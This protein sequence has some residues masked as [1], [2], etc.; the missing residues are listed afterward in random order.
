MSRNAT[1]GL[2]QRGRTWHIDKR[3]KGYGRLCE[4]CGTDSLEEAEKYLAMRLEQIRRAHV[5]GERPAV[6][7]DQAA[8]K[9][10][11]EN[12]HKKSIERDVISLS[13]VMP[14]IGEMSL[15]LVHDGSLQ[16]YK[17]DRLASGKAAGTINRELGAVRR[18]LNLAA[19]AW[20]HD[21][22]MAYLSNTPLIQMLPD[23]QCRKPYPINT[24]EQTRLF[25]QMSEHLQ[26]A[27]LFAL[28]T[29]LREAELCNLQWD[30]EVPVPELETSV[31]ILPERVTKTGQERVVMLNKVARSVI[32]ARRGKHRTHVFSY[33]GKPV[34]R[35]NNSGFRGARRRAGL[36]QV[37]VHDLRHTFGHRLRAAGVSLEDRKDLLGHKS[38]EITTHYSA[39][40]LRRLLEGA[41][42][43]CKKRPATILRVAS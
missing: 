3:I 33:K 36:P 40:D 39:P 35:L 18:I 13:H 16:Q 28:N 31:F 30:W 37:R 15:E 20:R 23:Q 25:A 17:Q 1:R 43:I 42:S 26:Q 2:Q 19:R 24:D 32:R 4:S 12:Q 6:T 14:Y 7:F 9:Y 34:T 8:A 29:G 27:C 10:V 11:A 41:E 38:G 21:N 5:Y 22:G